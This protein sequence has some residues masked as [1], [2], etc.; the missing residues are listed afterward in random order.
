MIPEETHQALLMVSHE[1]GRQASKWGEQN[2]Q[3]VHPDICRGPTYITMCKTLNIPTADDAKANCDMSFEEGT[4]GWVDIL[5]EEF[6]EATEQAYNVMVAEDPVTLTEAEEKLY[7]ELIQTAA[8]ATQ[9][10]GAIRRRQRRR[11]GTQVD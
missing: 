4:G 5:L 11:D 7:T 6:C 2:H 8:V 1:L 10:A 9:W 3:D